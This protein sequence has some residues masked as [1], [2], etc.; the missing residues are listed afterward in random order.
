MFDKFKTLKNQFRT[1]YKFTLSKFYLV[2]I[3]L[4][5][6]VVSDNFILNDFVKV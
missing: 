4:R 2:E 5:L 6:I 3:H 1:A